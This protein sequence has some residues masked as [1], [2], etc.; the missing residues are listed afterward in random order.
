MKSGKRMCKMEAILIRWNV[1]VNVRLTM[2]GR[3]RI[4]DIP[5][6]AMLGR[7]SIWNTVRQAMFGMLKYM[8]EC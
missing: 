4:R 3:E 6:Q 1:Q 8:R 7:R 5:Q 2:L